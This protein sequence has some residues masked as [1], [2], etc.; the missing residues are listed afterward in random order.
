M[1]ET[2]WGLTGPKEIGTSSTVRWAGRSSY[3]SNGAWRSRGTQRRVPLPPCRP[4]LQNGVPGWLW[5]SGC[6]LRS[7]GPPG[8]NGDRDRP[9]MVTGTGKDQGTRHGLGYRPRTHPQDRS[10]WPTSN[11]ASRH[12][13]AEDRLPAG[14]GEGE[15]LE[16]PESRLT[17]D[18]DERQL[19]VTGAIS[20]PFQRHFSAT[21]S[22]QRPHL[23]S[24]ARTNPQVKGPSRPVRGSPRTPRDASALPRSWACTSST[25]YRYRSW[26]R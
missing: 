20:A 2:K 6:L 15:V 14:R 16:L 1:A 26:S 8:R 4:L 5:S 25:G 9:V 10:W 12:S 13:R 24:W 17:P 18:Q 21:I 19:S 23:T 22:P 3:G 7:H 11:S